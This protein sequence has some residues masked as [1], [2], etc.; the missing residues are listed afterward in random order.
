MTILKVTVFLFQTRSSPSGYSPTLS[1]AFATF[2]AF[3]IALV[4]VLTVRDSEFGYSGHTLPSERLMRTNLAEY[5]PDGLILMNY[6]R[7]VT[8]TVL[9]VTVTAA[10]ARDS[11][12]FVL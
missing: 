9:Y 2:P 12:V 5:A 7:I 6:P 8:V 4:L 10:V 3:C 11:V 1:S